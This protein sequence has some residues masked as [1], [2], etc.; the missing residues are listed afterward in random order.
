MP[1]TPSAP[2]TTRPVAAAHDGDVNAAPSISVKLSALHP[3]Y[4][5]AKRARVHGRTG[6]ARAG[7][8]AA[9][10]V[11]RHRLTIDAEEADRLE[12]SLD[13]I[14]AAFADASLT[15]WEGFGWPC[16]P[17]RSAHRT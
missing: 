5:H 2:A 6:P 3:R 1:S 17:T 11:L 14:E 13:V 8:G 10:Q 15:G 4:E 12:L 7:T 9:G 16:R